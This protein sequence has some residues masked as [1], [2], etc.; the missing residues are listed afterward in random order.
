MQLPPCSPTMQTATP[1]RHTR[2]S[3]PRLRPRPGQDAL[4]TVLRTRFGEGRPA[5]R[6][7]A[8]W[9]PRVTVRRIGPGGRGEVG[10][11]ETALSRG[12]A[13]MRAV[14]WPPP[15]SHRRDLG[16]GFGGGPPPP[17]PVR[18]PK[19]SKG[20]GASP[21]QTAVFNTA[22]AGFRPLTGREPALRA[23]SKRPQKTPGGT[24]SKAKSGSHGPESARAVSHSRQEFEPRRQG[25]GR[26]PSSST[27]GRS[28]NST[29]QERTR[30]ER[31]A[32]HGAPFRPP[33]K[34]TPD[35]I[36]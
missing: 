14:R 7:C 25:G 36:G 16:R 28:P 34:I 27:A 8:R 12:P 18:K 13:P 4:P 9:Q 26:S 3:P 15:D 29:G 6:R 33:A 31:Q 2:P 24:V 22:S 32:P 19:G 11:G 30:E 10:V 1:A 35:R 17:K 20:S 21:C 5:N 23:P